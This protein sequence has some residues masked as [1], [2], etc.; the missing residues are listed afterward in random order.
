MLRAMNQPSDNYIA[1]SLFRA[2]G[3]AGGGDWSWTAGE[4]AMAAFLKRAGI[5]PDGLRV[6]DGSGLSRHNA[7][8]P[9]QVVRLLAFMAR[10]RHAR[11][12]RD[13]LPAPGEGTLKRR[14]NNGAAATALRAKTGTLTGASNLSGYV[15]N[16][17]KNSL[18]FSLMSNGY[19]VPAKRVRSLQ[20]RV[21]EALA[22][23]SLP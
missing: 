23:S 6:V 21:C 14:M 22:A 3:R 18:I 15:Q 8:S 2:L 16:R 20:D 1:E 11:V 12:F 10:H 19:L 9:R 7:V 17:S 13:S 5:D 4:K